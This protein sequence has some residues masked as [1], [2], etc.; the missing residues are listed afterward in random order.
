MGSLGRTTASR[1]GY[2]L[3]RSAELATQGRQ[4]IGLDLIRCAA[5]CMVVIFHLGNVPELHAWTWWGWVGVPIFFVLSGFVISYSAETASAASFLRSRFLRLAPGVW[6]CG[7]ITAVGWLVVGG[8]SAVGQRYIDTLILWPWGPWIDGVYWT[9]PIEIA[10]YLLIFGLVLTR[11]MRGAPLVFGALSAVS[12]AYWI[13]RLIMQRW[14]GALPLWATGLPGRDAQLLLLEHGCYFALGG[15][16]WHIF[17][18][19]LT[20]P[21]GVVLVVAYAGGVL[22]CAFFGRALSSM[23]LAV[24]EVVWTL[25]VASVVAAVWQRA[26]IDRALSRF[27]G[28]IRIAGL[29]TYPLYL[30]HDAAGM[31]IRDAPW[32][33]GLPPW[34]AAAAAAA[35]AVAASIFITAFVEPAVR[36][37]LR[38]PLDLALRLRFQPAAHADPL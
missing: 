17:R 20:R 32:L 11:T 2:A 6:I 1:Y 27:Y 19:G 13:E 28:P 29:A 34:L 21:L 5:A 4:I 18:R 16:L 30:L 33:A 22:Q 23:P 31:M 12:L 26:R 14:P 10:F 38:K 36:A 37:V 7:T 3:G 8:E 35:V 25:A 9:L 24:P 15:A